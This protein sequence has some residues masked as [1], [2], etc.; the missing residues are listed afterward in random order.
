MPD[1]IDLPASRFAALVAPAIDRAFIG[2][3]HAA[4]DN[5]GHALVLAY[6]GR[7]AGTLIELRNPLAAG[8]TVGHEITD[9]PYRYQN[10]DEVMHSLQHSAEQ[11]LLTRN[12]DGRFAA[13]EHGSAFLNDLYAHHSAVLAERW[14]EGHSAQ[15]KRLIPL[16]GRVMKAAGDTGGQGWAVFAPPHEPAGST[17]GT[18][19]LNRLSTL[20]AHRADAHAAAWQEA[21]L[22]VGEILAM[23]PGPDRDA[24]EDDTN[25]RAGVPYESLTPDERLTLLA[26]LAALP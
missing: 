2:A 24:I 14:E 1:V 16:T 17:P 12:R 4:R 26:D 5:G 18:I 11:G 21:G 15:L 20:R 19:L 9:G 13:T 25:T 23:E 6:G 10:P 7:A 8:R 3:M 22:T